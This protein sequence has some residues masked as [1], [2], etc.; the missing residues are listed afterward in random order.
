MSATAFAPQVA[1]LIP[2]PVAVGDAH[3]ITGKDK[4]FAVGG[5]VGRFSDFATK[6]AEAA[7]KKSD[8]LTP[9]AQVRLDANLKLPSGV[10]FTKHGLESLAS[11]TQITPRTVQNLLDEF[12]RIHVLIWHFCY[13]VF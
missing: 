7:T 2:A 12:H 4:P 8:R 9:E 3:Y 13:F 10:G 11:M 1:P 5:T 6:V